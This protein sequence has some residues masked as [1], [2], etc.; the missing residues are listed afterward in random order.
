MIASHEAD[1][2]SNPSR[3]MVAWV[4]RQVGMT[5]S[6]CEANAHLIAQAPRMYDML[7]DILGFLQ[8]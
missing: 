4:H 5:N 2:I 3:G 6:E 1:R 7:E 8:T